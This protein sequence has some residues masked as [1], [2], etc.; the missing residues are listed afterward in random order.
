[1]F[2]SF[3]SSIGDCSFSISGSFC[4][5]Q[6][7]LDT[8]AVQLEQIDSRSG[9]LAR[10]CSVLEA[11]LAEAQQALIE[12]KQLHVTTQSHLREVEELT[13]E[14]QEQL[15]EQ[16]DVVRQQEAKISAQNTQVHDLLVLI[17]CYFQ[18]LCSSHLSPKFLPPKRLPNTSSF[19][20]RVQV[21]LHKSCS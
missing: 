7:E 9:N 16:T 14:L 5:L 13:V 21:C 19:S 11:Q 8:A 6:A 4:V 18:L 10:Q 15:E 3:F 12:E 2:L 20:F 17:L 1:M